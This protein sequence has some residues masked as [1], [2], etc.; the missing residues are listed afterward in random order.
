[1]ASGGRNESNRYQLAGIG[2]KKIFHEL[3]GHDVNKVGIK[4]FCAQEA[5]R[6]EQPSA[7]WNRGEEN[8]S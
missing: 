2:Q 7:R 4:R 3:D 8:F 1:M 5:E 6:V